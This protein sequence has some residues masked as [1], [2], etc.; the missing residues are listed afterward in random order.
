MD[1]SILANGQMVNKMERVNTFFR[2]VLIVK[3]FGR[4]DPELNG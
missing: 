2:M 1:T 4:T 3:E